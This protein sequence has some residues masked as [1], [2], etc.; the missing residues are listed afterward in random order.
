MKTNQLG[1]ASVAIIFLAI[2]TTQPVQAS[3]FGSGYSRWCDGIGG[4]GATYTKPDSSSA[5]DYFDNN[6]FNRTVI[7]NNSESFGGIEMQIRE[8][9]R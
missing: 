8:T 7:R 9:Y 1:F 2:G 4:Q 6:G 3:C 5:T